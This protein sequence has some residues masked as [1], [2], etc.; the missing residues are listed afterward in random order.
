MSR[1]VR[2]GGGR[3]ATAHSNVFISDTG[4]E[5]SDSDQIWGAVVVWFTA[6]GASAEGCQSARGN[7]NIPLRGVWS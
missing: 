5:V 7:V 6:L 2:G 4:S 1:A 3:K